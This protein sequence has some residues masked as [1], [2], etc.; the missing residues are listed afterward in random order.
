MPSNKID[1]VSFHFRRP[2]KIS[3]KTL[4]EI[5][6]LVVSGGAVGTAWVDEILKSAFLIGY[7]KDAGGRVVG[8]E[9]LKTP[10]EAYRKKIETA[11]GLDLSGYLERGYAAVEEGYRGCGILDTLVGGL[12]E[13]AQGRKAYVTTSM[14]NRPVVWLTEKHGMR[15]A[16]RY[17][18]PGTGREIGVFISR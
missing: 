13:R 10:K 1:S 7:A 3:A 9:V 4:A 8:C 15:L 11:T 2:E 16:G 5:R 6:D 12:I 14:D 17:V 18:N